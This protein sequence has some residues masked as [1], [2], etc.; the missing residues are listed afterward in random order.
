MSCPRLQ[1][2]ISRIICTNKKYK[3]INLK[4]RVQTYIGLAGLAETFCFSRSTIYCSNLRIER[5]SYDLEMKT[6]E[7]NRNNKRPE[8]EL[9]DWFIERI[10]SRL[11]FGWLSERTGAREVSRN[12]PILRFD[13]TLQ[14]NWPVEQC[15][16]HIMVFFGG[17]TKRPCFDLFIH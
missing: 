16:I 7:Q 5:F 9:F 15:L 14:H 3:F 8:I 2:L 10:Q 6:R 17:E 12:Q 4:A 11:A 1:C 13:V